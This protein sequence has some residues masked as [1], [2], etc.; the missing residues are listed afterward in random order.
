MLLVYSIA[1]PEPRDVNDR[2]TIES[3]WFVEPIKTLDELCTPRT[4]FR[5]PRCQ[6][7]QGLKQISGPLLIIVDPSG[8]M[9]VSEVDPSDSIHVS[10]EAAD[11]QLDATL[12]H[13]W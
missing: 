10:D 5:S 3:L 7:L 2:W 11:G 12:D 9:H 6:C 4:F 1:E 13:V 8:S